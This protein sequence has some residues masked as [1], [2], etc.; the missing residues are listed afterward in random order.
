MAK[1]AKAPAKKT[2]AKP[3]AKAKPAP[4]A[5]KAA[6]PEKPEKAPVKKIEVKP[7]PKAT[8]K[9]EPKA[10]Q[11]EQAPTKAANSATE[12][13]LAKADKVKAP[14]GATEDL[15]KWYDYRNK[16]GAEKAL[17]YSMSAVFEA[18]KP[19]EHKVMGW[20]WIV[21][22]QNDRLEVLFEQGIKYLI[23]N[24]KPR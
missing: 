13:K 20:G 5:V 14:E 21:N 4:K 11:K 9:A 12:A 2:P 10:L 7:A 15:K 24:Y 8:S 6:K 23:S 18:N 17:A 22:I 1:A 19:I 16:H 3:A